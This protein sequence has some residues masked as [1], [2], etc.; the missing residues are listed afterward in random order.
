[1]WAFGTRAR[2]ARNVLFDASLEFGRNWRLDVERLPVLN[3]DERES[4]ADEVRDTRN[5]IE[6]LVLERWDAVQGN[7]SREDTEAAEAA[8]R[9]SYPW[10]DER[11]IKHAVSQ[12]TYY[13]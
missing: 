12:S 5:A 1:M 6:Q 13:A 8:V 11:N 10:M 4:L 9:A 7:W 3:P 2:D